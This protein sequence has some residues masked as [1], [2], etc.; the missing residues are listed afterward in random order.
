MMF[1]RSVIRFSIS[2]L[3][4]ADWESPGS[5]PRNRRLVVN[6]HGGLLGPFGD[7]LE[8]GLRAAFGQRYVRD[9]IERD[10][11]VTSPAQAA[12]D[13]WPRPFR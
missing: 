11:I 13:A 4:S 9:F 7:D 8:Q 5:I 2:A 12:T 1:A 10:Q 3:H 6:D